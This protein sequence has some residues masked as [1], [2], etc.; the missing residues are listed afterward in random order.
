MNIGEAAGWAVVIAKQA[1]AKPSAV[2]TKELVRKLT[3][4]RV[5]VS[6]FN[7]VDL[8]SSDA[9]IPAVSYFATQGFFPGYD[10]KSTEPLDEGTARVWADACSRLGRGREVDPMETARAVASSAGAAGNAPISHGDFAELAG[11]QSEDTGDLGRGEACRL[12][13]TALDAS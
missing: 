3:D 2:D 5:M 1:G 8:G 4:N 10:A 12:L 13:Y 7:D 6:F 9:S 11:V